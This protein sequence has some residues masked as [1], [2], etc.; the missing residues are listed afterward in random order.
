MSI[1][2]M[3]LEKLKYLKGQQA[4]REERGA[5]FVLT[6]LLLPL[7]LGFTGFA[8][9]VGNLYM[10]KARLQNAADAAALAGARAFVNENAAKR[11]LLRDQYKRN[12]NVTSIPADIRNS[13]NDSA[14]ADAKTA[15]K[16]AAGATV[17]RNMVNLQNEYQS[18]YFLVTGIIHESGKDYDQQYF[19]ANLRETVPLYFIPI[20]LNKKEQ[21]VAAV[22]ISTII[23]QKK[24]K[25]NNNPTTTAAQSL[26]MVKSG[27]TFENTYASNGSENQAPKWNGYYDGDLRYVGDSISYSFH[28]GLNGYEGY[29]P[30]N[31]LFNSRA[32]ALKEL[33]EKMSGGYNEPD[34]NAL[35]NAMKADKNLYSVNGDVATPTAEG[36]VLLAKL[37]DLRDGKYN[38]YQVAYQ[39]VYNAFYDEFASNT[40]YHSSFQKLEDYDM[41]LF[42]KKV[43][44]LFRDKLIAGMSQDDKNAVK[45][46]FDK[47]TA[48][49]NNNSAAYVD[50]QSTWYEGWKQDNLNGQN[51]NADAYGG[52]WERAKAIW[53]LFQTY[54]NEGSVDKAKEK[55]EADGKPFT[56][57]ENVFNSMYNGWGKMQNDP[58]VYKTASEWPDWQKGEFA[59]YQIGRPSPSAENMI[60]VSEYTG[61][62]INHQ[63]NIDDY[64]MIANNGDEYYAQYNGKPGTNEYKQT[65]TAAD[66]SSSLYSKEHSYFY[67]SGIKK[68]FDNSIVDS[69]TLNI[70]DDLYV[71]G[72]ITTDTPFYLFLADRIPSQIQIN[73]DVDLNRPLIVC[74]MG[75]K[76]NVDLNLNGHTFRGIMYT[77]NSSNNVMLHSYGGTQNNPSKGTFEGTWMS[78]GLQ[79]KDGQGYYKYVGYDLEDSLDAAMPGYTT[80]EG[81]NNNNDDDEE[82]PDDNENPIKVIKLV[83][84]VEEVKS[85][86]EI[87]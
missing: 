4:L 5:I 65:W 48:T 74:Y 36:A 56:K 28:D 57:D 26:F 18:A 68:Y 45:T 41:D 69:F 67:Y 52:E 49:W 33:L 63:P 34:Y 51:Y 66:I 39:A 71:G 7:L 6:A 76:A 43:K 22:G 72:A 30:Y 17:N 35:I 14:K 16:T 73:L 19:R 23:G 38:D 81:N 9:D 1:Y 31:K 46:A 58:T 24:E 87:E 77:P 47:D 59:N 55:W 54:K 78:D 75:N 3:F 27:I 60:G 37:Q 53:I 83:K 85:V 8:Y 62:V 79:V 42:G 64:Y 50:A 44:E 32:F 40:H 13:I 82:D 86:E 84:T 70:D 61:Q 25:Q 10:Y 15:A 2:K 20:I 11:K 80:E 21:D 12:N 29:Q